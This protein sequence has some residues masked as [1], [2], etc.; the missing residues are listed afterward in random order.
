MAVWRKFTATPARRGFDPAQAAAPN[1]VLPYGAILNG[2]Y[3][4]GKMLGR[5]GFGITYIGFDLM[6]QR[7]VARQGI[8]PLRSGQ[9][10]FAD[11]H[12]TAMAGRRAG[13]TSSGKTVSVPASGKPGRWQR[14]GDIPEVVR[15]LDCFQENDTAYIVMDYVSGKNADVRPAGAGRP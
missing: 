5:G 1:Y 9:P 2:R 12:G 10:Y 3:I 6:L 11:K 13:Q 4:V 15:V 14:S 7:K 8:F